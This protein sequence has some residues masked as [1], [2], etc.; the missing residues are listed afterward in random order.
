MANANY[1]REV[2]IYDL[3]LDGNV[4]FTGTVNDIAEK[5]GISPSTVYNRHRK[6]LYV[7]QE[8]RRE[9]RMLTRKLRQESEPHKIWIYQLFKSDEWLFTGTRKE[10]AEFL[11]VRM[12]NLVAYE[13]KNGIRRVKLRMECVNS[14]D[15]LDETLEIKDV[16]SNKE[17]KQRM[18]K[19]ITMKA[20]ALCGL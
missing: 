13:Q 1:K 16:V 7:L 17:D 6:G 19:Y 9:L 11:G 15:K 2:I 12:E 4:V 3:I 5:L 10:C 14:E 8:K 20:A 18:R